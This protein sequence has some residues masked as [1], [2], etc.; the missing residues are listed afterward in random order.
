[1]DNLSAVCGFYNTNRLS[2]LRLLGGPRLIGYA[3]TDNL[4]HIEAV[5]LGGDL[6]VCLPCT[7]AAS[8][9]TSRIMRRLRIHLVDTHLFGGVPIDLD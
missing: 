5:D 6:L 9:H 8:N 2:S 1:M 7:L 3:T 4:G